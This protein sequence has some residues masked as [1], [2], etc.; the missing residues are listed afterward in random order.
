MKGRAKQTGL[1]ACDESN[2]LRRRFLIVELSHQFFVT[3][4]GIW[5]GKVFVVGMCV[6]T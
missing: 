3:R 1:A 5:Q 4:Q 6:S 2:V